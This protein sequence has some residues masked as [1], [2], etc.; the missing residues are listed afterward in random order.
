MAAKI[1]PDDTFDEIEQEIL[2]TRA[3]LEADPDARDLLATT[4]AWMPRV[5]DARASERNARAAEMR[6][7]AMRRVANGRLDAA[8]Q[9]FGDELYLAVGKDASSAR[10]T[11]YFSGAERTVSTFIRQAFGAQIARVRAWLDVTGDAVL[12]RHR[13]ALDTWSAAGAAA[14]VQ[15]SGSATVRGEARIAREVL[16]EDLTRARDGLEVALVTRAQERDLQRTW[17]SLFFRVRTRDA[18]APSPSPP[19]A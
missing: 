15:T 4:D 16:A 19:P 3:A 8:C 2:Y 18:E 1:H 5:D 7:A 10:W 13:E 11:R 17:P 14:N 6:A 9:S 12:D